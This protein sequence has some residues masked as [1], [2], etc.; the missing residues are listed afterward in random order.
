MAAA[1]RSFLLERQAAVRAEHAA[2]VA[3]IAELEGRR[4]DRT[5]LLDRLLQETYRA[6]RTNALGVF[7]SSGSLVQTL[8]YRDAL[9][10]LASQQLALTEELRRISDEVR[11]QEEGLARQ[12][13]ELA[14]LLESVGAKEKLLVVLQARAQALV[15]VASGGRA[16]AEI[17]VLTQ[18]A[19]EVAEASTASDELIA[20]A[21][22]VANAPLPQA[23]SWVWP[24]RGVISQ[25]FGPTLLPL[26]PPR[27]YGGIPYPHFHDAIDVAAPLRTPVTAAA[28]GLV[29][30]VGHLPDGAMIVVIA[31]AG[32]IVTLY[33]HLDDTVAPPTV[34]AG[35]TV[36]AGD[37][38]GAVGMTGITTGPHLHFVVR[39]GDLPLDPRSMLP[40]GP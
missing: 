39:R 17:D 16:A 30:F 12:E 20:R 8:V 36:A 13:A 33:A 3:R 23:A 11:R 5:A 24:V 22:A 34:H 6:T 26:E 32:G 35:D 4:L 7:L 31:H 27:T 38:I 37:R 1:E 21:A 9:A 10:A 19:Q 15:A 25:P 18:L 28:P 40:D 29:T 2:G 14:M